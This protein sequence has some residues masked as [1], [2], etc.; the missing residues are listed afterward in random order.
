MP[1]RVGYLQALF[2]MGDAVVEDDVQIEGSGP[3][4]QAPGLP[5]QLCL[6]SPSIQSCYY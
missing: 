5:P 2:F 4:S 1:A 3:P 6:H